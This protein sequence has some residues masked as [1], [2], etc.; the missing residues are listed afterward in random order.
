MDVL[1][2]PAAV[3]LNIGFFKRME[4]QLPWVRVKVAA[5]L[6]GRTA[7]A[8]GESQWITGPAARA[9]VQY[10]RARSC[11][12]VTGIGTV[13]ADDPQL[14]VRDDRLCGRWSNPSAAARGRRFD[15]AHAAERAL[16]QA[17]GKAL[18]AARRGR[19]I[20]AGRSCDAGAEVFETPVRVSTSRALFD[21]L[22]RRGV[23][24]VLVEAGAT[25]HRRGAAT[26]VVG[27][28]D[29][30]RRAEAARS[31][32]SPLCG[33]VRRSAGRCDR[34]HASPTFASLGDDL[35]LQILRIAA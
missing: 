19:A 1:P 29:R 9:D 2:R 7:M 28:S 34:R 5:S 22:A 3:E 33:T 30:L 23:N 16:L 6:D 25:R 20:A 12:I 17:P 27:R 11:A 14:N 21:A 15:V 8:Y 24:E 35:R 26:R 4:R 32:R 10:W 13:L 18:V 31:R